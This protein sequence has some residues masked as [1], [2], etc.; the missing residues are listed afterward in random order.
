MARFVDLGKTLCFIHNYI[1]R[2]HKLA[3]YDACFLMADSEAFDCPRLFDFPR[4][5]PEG[6]HRR[7]GQSNSE[8]LVIKNR[9]KSASNS[10]AIC[11]F[12]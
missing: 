3:L 11:N 8:E 4:A 2:A 7:R 5:K 12:T 1:L 9:I 10:H 6:N